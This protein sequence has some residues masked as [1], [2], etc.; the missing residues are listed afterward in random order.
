MRQ[1]H[2]HHRRQQAEPGIGNEVAEEG[3]VVAIGIG[4]GTSETAIGIVQG[5]TAHHN[6]VAKDDESHTDAHDTNDA[7]PLAR[8][9]LAK[10][11]YHIALRVTTDDKLAHHDGYAH[12]ENTYYINK[13]EGSTAIVA[14][15][16]GKAPDVAK[17]HGTTCRGKDSSH[18][19]TEIRM[20]FH[21]S[22]NQT[23]NKYYTYTYGCH[24]T[25]KHHQQ[26]SKP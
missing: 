22:A 16:H 17:T 4:Q 8:S 18:S 6:I 3:T 1:E 9:Q 2:E 20:F 23:V 26:R 5:P 12:E 15:Q 25:E 19:A 11:L 13:D 14:Y 7:P 24:P 21:L 10:C